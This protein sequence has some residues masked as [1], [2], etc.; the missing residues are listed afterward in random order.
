M[1][2][3]HYAVERPGTLTNDDR[4]NDTVSRYCTRFT[5][6]QYVEKE[7]K[8]CIW[9]DSGNHARCALFVGKRGN[10]TPLRMGRDWQIIRCPACIALPRGSII[11]VVTI[12]KEPV[13][14]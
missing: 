6:N 9:D 13:K 10:P 4:E 3:V 14:P 5:T 11:P 1:S 8:Y 12:T 2:S 7:C